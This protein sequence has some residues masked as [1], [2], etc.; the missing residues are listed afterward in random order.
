[1][2]KSPI[3]YT[4]NKYSIIDEIISI[5]DTENKKVVDMCSGGSTVGMNLQDA[6][7][8]HFVEKNKN[9]VNLLQFLGTTDFKKLFN[10]IEK[11]IDK[12]K[13]S[14]TNKYGTE[15]YRD[16]I[17][18]NTGLKNYNSEGYYKLRDDYNNSK[19]KNSVEAMI[20]LYLLI[21]YGFN[22]ELRFNS[23]GGFNIPCGKTDFNKN[24]YKKIYDFNKKFDTQKHFFH[25]LDCFSEEAFGIY[26]E[27]DVIYIDPPYLITKAGYNE[28]A[29]W[30]REDEIKLL[31]LI[32]KLSDAGKIIYLSNVLRNDGK[33]N[34]ILLNWCEEKKSRIVVHKIKKHYRSSSYNKI[35]RGQTEEVLIEVKNEN[36]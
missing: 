30:T 12:F 34:D 8:V 1:M 9:V 6:S 2:I 11:N 25:N 7:V 20:K 14:N 29:G 28:N 4:G 31:D 21:V 13:L 33:E 19:N 26:L 5:M 15:K 27:A 24:N 18:G 23:N 10:K 3:N 36:K 17:V 32:N 22:N 35:Q 16:S